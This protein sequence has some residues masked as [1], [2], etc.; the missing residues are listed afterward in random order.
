MI[1]KNLT[2]NSKK[3]KSKNFKTTR[4]HRGG[5]PIGIEVENKDCDC[6][7]KVDFTDNEYKFKIFQN[8]YNIINS[9]NVKSDSLMKQLSE[10][11]ENP[12]TV[13][14]TNLI[15]EEESLPLTGKG[16]FNIL[17]RMNFEM[18]TTSESNNLLIAQKK[19]VMF[20][21]QYFDNMIQN[22]I[23][24][25]KNPIHSKGIESQ[26]PSPI[27]VTEKD[28]EEVIPKEVEEPTDEELE[29]M[30]IWIQENIKSHP[31]LNKVEIKEFII[32]NQIYVPPNGDIEEK[33]FLKKLLPIAKKNES[34]VREINKKIQKI[35]DYQ[36]Q[37][38]NL[39]GINLRTG[40]PISPKEFTNYREAVK[41]GAAGGKQKG[42]K[43][44]GTRSGKK[45][46][47]IW[48]EVN[49]NRP[50]P[51]WN[52]DDMDDTERKNLEGHYSE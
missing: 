45:K 32:T 44:M 2:K 36:E 24:C 26:L 27:E 18:G 28:L 3:N 40:T 16:L 47:S 51:Y 14:F 13:T 17:Y 52:Y 46:E 10:L 31:P 41:S 50:N 21:K 4:K 48:D 6:G 43:P 8:I 22:I 42:G 9:G 7:T 35:E 11:E 39:K 20:D 23:E 33:N 38:R 12:G 15:G 1:R 37:M 49:D 19:S 29:N 25:E 34:V 30:S 5:F